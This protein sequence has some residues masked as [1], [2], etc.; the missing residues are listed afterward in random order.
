MSSVIFSMSLHA[1]YTVHWRIELSWPAVTRRLVSRKATR[2]TWLNGWA[3]ATETINSLTP[4]R[5][6]GNLLTRMGTSRDNEMNVRTRS[7]LGRGL[8]W[9]H[10]YIEGI[11]PKGPYLPCVPR[12]IDGLVQ[13]CSNSIVNALELL[14][15]CTKPS[16]LTT[17]WVLPLDQYDY[18]YYLSD[19]N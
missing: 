1:S 12:Y 14:Q 9:S 5:C 6:D 2:D 7:H 15:S 17:T 4:G 8:S 13:D 11:L 3:A 19:E 16:V 10:V 18:D